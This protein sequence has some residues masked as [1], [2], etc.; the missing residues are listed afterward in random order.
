FR[1]VLAGSTGSEEEFRP[2]KEEIG[3]ATNIEV[4]GFISE[5]T[6]LDLYSKAKVFAL[7]SLWE[8]VG[9]VALD[10]AVFGCK[11]V[12]TKN[13][14]PKEYYNGMAEVVDPLDIDSIG[15]SILKLLNEN[16]NQS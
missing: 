8:G 16:G 14:G 7:P 2:I 9:I 6:K 12:I 1:L 3:D 15:T 4:L 13:G 11:I 5:E 10:A